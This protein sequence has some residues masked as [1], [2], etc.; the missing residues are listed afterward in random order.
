M[1]NIWLLTAT[2]ATLGF[3][4]TLIGPDHYL[5][6]IVISRARNWK[7]RKTLWVSFLCGLG[8]VLSSVALGFLGIALGMA[9]GHLEKVESTRGNI[10]SWLLIGF[11]LAYLVWGLR[12]AYRSKP[13]EHVHYHPDGEKHVHTHTHED[14]HIHIHEGQAESGEKKNITPWVLF[15]IF[16]FGPCEPL[17]PLVMY[18][19]AQHS[20]SGVVLV[21]AAFGL[22]TILTMLTI[23]ALSSWGLSFV[24][25]G[26]LERYSHALA[27]GIILV[28]GLAVQFL[29]L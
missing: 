23:I 10:A 7:L 22:T 14:G 29:G 8:H 11:G 17:I 27:G 9:V 21:T 19:A 20:T 12:K 28:S 26:G 6:F 16:V 3:V 24:R 25:L 18:P 4:H 5:P 2:A 15:L 1:Q 13:H